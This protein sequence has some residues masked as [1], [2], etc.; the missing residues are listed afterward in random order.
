MKKL[1]LYDVSYGTQNM[2]DY[3]IMKCIN[4]EME[5]LFKNKFITRYST[6]TPIA[7][8]YQNFRRN[9]MS[10]A[11]SSADKIFLCGANTIKKSLL[12]LSPD[13]NINIFNIKYYMNCI[14]IGVGTDDNSRFMDFYTKYIYK[15]IFSKKYIHS[16]R[17][18]RTKILFN[19]LGLDA[20]NTGCPTTWILT[21]SF[22]KDIPKDKSDSVIFTLTDYNRKPEYDSKLINILRKNYKKIYFWIQGSEDLEYIESLCNIDDIELISPDINEY[23]KVL[24]KG[25]I[26]YVGTRLHAGIFAMRHKVRSIII[27]IDNRTKDMSQTYHLNTIDRDNISELDNYIN[28]VISTEVSINEKAIKDWKKQFIE[29]IK[30]E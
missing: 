11:A 28:S 8:F 29:G 3:I 27:S 18:E 19:K 23:E 14:T 22:C 21:K 9:M 1:L 26:D 16:V 24:N 5:Y 20:I 15:K 2:G 6:H 4:E 10:K 17:D 7:R 12:R 13:W 25:K 30:Y